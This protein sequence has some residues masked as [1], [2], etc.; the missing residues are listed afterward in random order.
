[1]ADL[2]FSIGRKSPLEVVKR[3][4]AAHGWFDGGAVWIGARIGR[5]HDDTRKRCALPINDAR[6][7]AQIPG[8]GPAGQKTPIAR[9]VDRE[10]VTIGLA[11]S[12][13]QELLAFAVAVVKQG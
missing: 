13:V 11:H 4:Y 10:S 9:E 2:Q 8:V 1:M 3:L 12:P 7:V 6:H 5:I